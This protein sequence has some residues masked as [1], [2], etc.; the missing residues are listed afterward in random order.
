[1]N[2]LVKPPLEGEL[3]PPEEQLLVLAAMHPLK[4]SHELV[5]APVGSS[6]EEI[7]HAC[8]KQCQVSRLA[9]GAHVT[10]D[11]ITVPRVWWP[12]VRVRSG[13][14]V[15]VRA[16]PGKSMG[17]ILKSILSIALIVVAG[18]IVGPAVLGIAG[19]VAGNLISAA[20]VLGGNMLLNALFPP[21]TTKSESSDPVYSIASRQ[22]QSAKWG[23]IPAVLGRLRVA[24]KYAASPYTE[25][26]G[27]DQ[28]LHML[29]VWGLGPLKISDIQI[30]GTPIGEYQDVQIET[31]EGRAT[32]G[33]PTLYPSTVIQDDF[34]IEPEQNKP[35]VRTGADEAVAVSLD[36]MAPQGIGNIEKQTGKLGSFTVQLR[37]EI[38]NGV[39]GATA[40]NQVL[41]ITGKTRDPLRQSLRIDLPK[42]R[43]NSRV[44]R[45]SGDDTGDDHLEQVIWSALRSYRA[46]PAIQYGKPVA[47]TALRIRATKQLNGAISDLS[48]IVSTVARSYVDGQWREDQ[49]TRNPADLF[50]LVLQGPGNARPR[51][52]QNVD[53]SSIEAWADL[54]RVK[55]WT[56]DMN[57]DFPASVRETLRDICAAGRAVPIFRDGKWSVAMEDVAA[58]LVQVFTPRNVRNFTR[59]IT[60][61]ELPHALRVKFVNE[62]KDW[63]EDELIVYAEGYDRFSATLFETIELPGV[64]H[65]DNIFKHAKYREAEVKLRPSVYRFNTDAEHLI[66]TRGDRVKVSHYVVRRGAIQ[67]RVVAV[68]GQV[69][70]IDEPV[71]MVAGTTYAMDVRRKNGA[72]VTLPVTTQAGTG[73]D[74][75]VIGTPPAIGELVAIGEASQISLNCKILRIKPGPN[76]S[77]QIEVVDD[78]LEIQNA[79]TGP[80]GGNGGTVNPPVP[81]ATYRP[82]GLRFDS[83]TE[84]R[85]LGTVFVGRLF[86]TMVPP[87]NL[88]ITSYLVVAINSDGNERRTFV[89]PQT[90]FVQFEDLADGEWT[91]RVHAY[92]EGGKV[93]NASDPLTVAINIPRDQLGVGLGNV[94]PDLRAVLEFGPE[95]VSRFSSLLE[96]LA[97]NTASTNIVLKKESNASRALILEERTVRADETGALA[98]KVDGVIAELGENG[99]AAAIDSLEA[100]VDN[101]GDLLTASAE[102]LSGVEARAN[103]A[104]ASGLSRMEVVAGPA[105]VSAR[106]AQVLRVSQGSSFRDVG[107]YMDVRNDGVGTVGV[108][109]QRF[110][111]TDS[112]NKANPFRFEN[113][114]LYADAAVLGSLIVNGS[115]DGVKLS[116]QSIDTIHLKARSVNTDQLT[117]GGVTTDILG[118]QAATAS[119]IVERQ[120]DFNV[121][122][123]SPFDYIAA[124]INMNV[125]GTLL[126]IADVRAGSN[127][128]DNGQTSQGLEVKIKLN[129]SVITG[130]GYVP[131]KLITYIDVPAGYHVIKLYIQA[132]GTVGRHRGTRLYVGGLKR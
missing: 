23:P 110:F 68:D 12:R 85:P 3:L 7:V 1:M 10:I 61:T 54:C 22:N 57:R 67:G 132:Y 113:G 130:G 92:F 124:G 114:V 44:T 103:D 73:N 72:V 28:F 100:R 80:I 46:E 75:T 123:N 119:T 26:V 93:S 39:T 122:V 14:H 70:M 56:F 99:F 120:D 21:S 64:T 87:P 42:G 78:A 49:E 19:S 13:A 25:I 76:F 129:D 62:T 94:M 11:G 29:F 107:F 34:Q 112:T 15:V 55:G 17:N 95:S 125:A 108:D 128:L 40:Y 89:D 47:V 53:L 45:L 20:I 71:T 41:S 86:W 4:P 18:F 88:N 35:N 82:R 32:D 66:C 31:F 8:A 81:I 77:A 101:Q 38:I 24:P 127:N 91:F 83:F 97:A 2:A 98:K 63:I 37:V 74:V 65:P 105:G 36:F 109:A 52:N 115:I 5:F 126:I 102:R 79:D 27:N 84:E 33:K 59:S 43:Y 90:L 96:E 48:G 121:A 50:R 58:P 6:V 51:T 111:V 118:L 116:A 60:Y 104:T 16:V 106:F 131:A 30:A 9:G 69:V 117:I